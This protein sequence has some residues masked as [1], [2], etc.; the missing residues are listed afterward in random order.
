MHMY[1]VRWVVRGYIH[2]KAC[3]YTWRSVNVNAWVCAGV[4]K[5]I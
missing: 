3:M 4:G 2:A 1:T 5:G